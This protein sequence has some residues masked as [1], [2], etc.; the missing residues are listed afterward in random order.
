M[1][2]VATTLDSTDTERVHPHRNSIGHLCIEKVTLSVK[3]IRD[4]RRKNKVKGMQEVIKII[5]LRDYSDKK[6]DWKEEALAS[7]QRFQYLCPPKIYMSNCNPK[8]D[9]SIRR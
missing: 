1:C 8:C 9:G 3:L 7:L 5:Q 2:L 6:C 4:W